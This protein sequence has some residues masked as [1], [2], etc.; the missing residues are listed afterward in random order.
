MGWPEHSA[1]AFGGPA[2]ARD[3]GLAR[4]PRKRL[5]SV[6]LLRLPLLR[7]SLHRLERLCLDQ[8]L[9]SSGFARRRRL[10]VKR[11]RH[12]IAGVPKP[13]PAVQLNRKDRPRD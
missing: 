11:R 13:W 12:E 8:H 3:G 2:G 1:P 4:R 5:G 10:T 9:L 6:G 7:R